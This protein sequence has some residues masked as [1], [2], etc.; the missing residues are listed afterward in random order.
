MF[1]T[2]CDTC[3]QLLN[4][5]YLTDVFSGY[6]P[7][8]MVSPGHYLV[9]VATGSPQ[10]TSHSAKIAHNTFQAKLHATKNAN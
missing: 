9:A 1:V 2:C 7:I 10:H 4:T 5:A 3:F 8:L 6:P